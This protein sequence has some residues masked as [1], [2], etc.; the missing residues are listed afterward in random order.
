MGVIAGILITPP[1]AHNSAIIQIN[2]PAPAQPQTFNLN[3][4]VHDKLHSKVKKNK[5]IITRVLVQPKVINSI[6]NVGN[7]VKTKGRGVGNNKTRICRFFG[8]GV[9]ARSSSPVEI[10]LPPRVPTVTTTTTANAAIASGGHSLVVR[11]GILYSFGRNSSRGGGG[12]GSKPISD[13]GQLGRFPTRFRFPPPSVLAPGIVP[14]LSSEHIKGGVIVKGIGAGR[15]HS[16]AFTDAPLGGSAVYTSAVYT[17]AVY[18]WGLNDYGQ[19]GRPG[20]KTVGASVAECSSGGMC[21]SGIP[22]LVQLPV[23][24]SAAVSIPAQDRHAPVKV[25]AVAAG[26]YFSLVLIN[27]GNVFT[28]GLNACG[29]ENTEFIEQR[30]NEFLTNGR[31]KQ[32]GSI[33][34]LQSYIA[35]PIPRRI[36]INE[37][38]KPIVAMDTG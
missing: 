17:S 10:L 28:F 11:N 15:Y 37:K 30:K 38:Y 31:Y 34:S 22:M 16:I 3:L 14:R 29:I 24:A 25:V 23:S 5:K 33:K 4:N 21:R 35:L 19:L 26:R 20:V 7:L 32:I 6:V 12:Y 9:T 27:D 36:H 2:V 8:W 1:L 13:S 18:T